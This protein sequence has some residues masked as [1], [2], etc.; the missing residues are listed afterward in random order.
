M[1]WDAIKVTFEKWFISD[2][3]RLRWM[4]AGDGEETRVT[5]EAGR[6]VTRSKAATLL[7]RRHEKH[8]GSKRRRKKRGQ[9]WRENEKGGQLREDLSWQERKWPQA[10]MKNN[11]RWETENLNKRCVQFRVL[12]KK[13]RVQKRRERTDTTPRTWWGLFKICRQTG[14]EKQSSQTDRGKPSNQISSPAPSFILCREEG[15]FQLAPAACAP[16]Q[17]TCP[18]PLTLADRAGVSS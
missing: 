4:D 12:T 16:Q 17:K 5:D 7:Q 9:S 1:F 8:S 18:R 13:F 14:N 6:R 11:K 3:L 10:P 2:L 15:P